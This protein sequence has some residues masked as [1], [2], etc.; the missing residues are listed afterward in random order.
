MRAELRGAIALEEVGELHEAARVFEYAGEHARAAALRLEYAGTLKEETQRIAVLREGVAHNAGD[1]K[2]GRAL[3]LAL[4]EALLARADALEDGALRRSIQLEAARALEGADQGSRSG[5]LY[6]SLGLLA[7]A[8]RAYERAGDINRLEYVHAVLER[9]ER[10]EAVLV[11]LENDVE[12]AWRQG[13]RREA[14]M[15]LGDHVRERRHLGRQPRPLLARRLATL[16]ES[17]PRPDRI[18]L[19]WGTGRVTHIRAAAEFRIGRDPSADLTVTGAS[20]SRAHVVLRMDSG[21]ASGAALVAVEQG[22]RAGTFWAGEPL[23]P[24]EPVVIDGPGELGLGFATAVDLHPLVYGKG[25]PCGALA[26]TRGASAWS[27][28]LPDGGPIVLAPDTVAPARLD[29]DG[30]YVL[31]VVASHTAAWLGEEPLG[32]GARVELLIGDRLVLRPAAGDELTLE[33]LA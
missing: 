2:E 7:R 31:V 6:E 13:R 3:H 32:K 10:A 4:A 8:A 14:H 23:Q 33:V 5:E 22:S 21:A 24:G 15:L 29:L 9:Q 26:R 11:A 16:E 20:L 28:F 25:G 17:L 27:L 30:G 18:D 19:A 1:T 12:T